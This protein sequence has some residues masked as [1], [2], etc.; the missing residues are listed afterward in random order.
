MP[1]T[2]LSVLYLDAF[3]SRSN[4]NVKSNVKQH[5]MHFII[6]A[7]WLVFG[8]HNVVPV[9]RMTT[10]SH[11]TL[12]DDE[13]NNCD[14]NEEEGTN[15]GH[16]KHCKSRIL[17]F[18]WKTRQYS[19]RDDSY[20]AFGFLPHIP[21]IPKFLKLSV[22]IINANHYDVSKSSKN[23]TIYYLLLTKEKCKSTMPVSYV[24]KFTF[25]L[26][27]SYD[28]H[29]FTQ[30]IFYLSGNESF[31]I[32][33]VDDQFKIVKLFVSIN[34]DKRQLNTHMFI[35]IAEQFQNLNAPRSGNVELEIW[36]YKNT[37]FYDRNESNYKITLSGWRFSC[38][39]S[40][41]YGSLLEPLI[42]YPLSHRNLYSKFVVKDA[43]FNTI[44]VA[45]YRLDNGR[46]I[47]FSNGDINLPNL[48]FIKL[49]YINGNDVNV[50]PLIND[51]G[52][53]RKCY[54]LYTFEI[55]GWFYRNI[56]FG[57]T[58][59]VLY[60]YGS[61]HDLQILAQANYSYYQHCMTSENRTAVYSE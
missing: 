60:N 16:C 19:D 10:L 23:E 21:A 12:G 6:K 27:I 34:S 18:M 39:K 56:L 5:S 17:F 14:Q 45:Y 51:Q 11:R 50:L 61:T 4:D 30:F 24:G 53:K 13:H 36:I 15:I 48:N 9:T 40:D 1:V 55:V 38:H 44:D 54:F 41:N 8:S 29:Y 37:T 33:Q 49:N 22:E 43:F 3:G 32:H 28:K 25:S 59:M 20:V 46:R 42:A 47:I 2:G 58:F 7:S 31:G 35:V 57:R 26:G 52:E